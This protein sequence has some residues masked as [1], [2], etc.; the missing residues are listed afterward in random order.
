MDNPLIPAVKYAT[1]ITTGD[2]VKTAWEFNFAGGYISPEHVKAFT[3]DTVTGELVIRPLTLIGPNTAEITPAVAAGLRLIVYRDTPKTAPLVDYSTGSILNESS[4]DKSNKQAV[5]IAAELADRVVADYDFSNALLYAVTTATT[6]SMVANGVDAKASTALANSSNALSTVTLL[7]EIVYYANKPPFNVVAN[8]TADQSVKLQAVYNAA[9][10]TGGSI[11]FDQG[12]YRGRIDFSGTTKQ[13]FFEGRGSSFVPYSGSQGEVFYCNNSVGTGTFFTVNCL[14][15]DTNVVGRVPGAGDTD[16]AGNCMYGVNF[17]SCSAI[18]YGS[19]FSYGKVA[20]YRGFYHQY[21][22][23]Y[24][25]TWAAAVFSTFTTGLLLD[26]NGTLEASN[27]NI[28]VRPKLFSSRYGATIRGGIKNRILCPTVQDIRSGGVGI[29]LTADS[30]GFGADGTTVSG[31]YGEINAGLTML[32][33]VAPNTDVSSASLLSATIIAT[34]C[35]NLSLTDITQYGSSAVTL[36]HPAGNDDHPA[37]RVSGGNVAIN[38]SGL[39]PRTSVEIDQPALG[40]FRRENVSRT[41]GQTGPNAVVLR[42]MDAFGFKTVARN[43]TQPLFTVQQPAFNPAQLRSYC[44]R[45]YLTVTGNAPETT[46]F[47]YA[48]HTQEHTVFVTC[49]SSGLPQVFISPARN[50]VDL[51]IAPTFT[52]IGEVVVTATTA[53]E[54]VTIYAGYVGA[55]SSPGVTATV[56]VA[57]EVRGAS[58]HPTQV[59]KA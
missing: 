44:F 52:S 30:T 6:A 46:A 34:S 14:F 54:V 10:A 49:N 43:T 39:P 16:A 17:I 56:S 23:F 7:A 36:S 20:S 57:Y 3:E 40:I 41:S 24:D 27:E 5:F 22:Q 38:T 47:G 32:I 18:W 50:L 25:C 37:V 11:V 13:V 59:S 15:R 26:G 58:F 12:T 4:L 48:A 8:S 31:L 28:L 53:G 33:G 45:L 29:W 51:G 1:L 55:G 2:G 35:Y 19:S 42:G 21:G 9:K